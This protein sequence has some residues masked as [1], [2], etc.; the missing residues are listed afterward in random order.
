MLMCI[1]LTAGKRKRGLVKE[2]Y[3]IVI[4]L[5]AVLL[6]ALCATALIVFAALS[7][8]KLQRDR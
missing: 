8:K 4:P 1:P 2:I 3:A 6:V 5:I 7:W